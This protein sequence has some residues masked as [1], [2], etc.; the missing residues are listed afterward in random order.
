MMSSQ[1]Q[2]LE[3]LFSFTSVTV[4][5]CLQIKARAVN[6]AV[7]VCIYDIFQAYFAKATEVEKLNLGKFWILKFG[8][9]DFSVL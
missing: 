1:H 5:Y 4:S 8:L 7:K 9:S 6:D 3:F 2:V